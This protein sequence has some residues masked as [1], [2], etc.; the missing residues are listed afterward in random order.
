MKRMSCWMGM[1]LFLLFGLA[2]VVQAA[3]APDIQL[4]IN[5]KKI[6]SAVPPQM[7]NDRTLV[8]VYVVKDAM[9]MNVGWDSKS[10]RVT[11]AG[12]DKKIE[13]VI[14]SKKAK[15]NGS[16]RT[17]DVAPVI[18]SDRTF[19][20]FRSVGE[21]LGMN[22]DWDSKTKSVHLT[23]AT[24]EKVDKPTSV[25]TP[26]KPVAKV[27]SITGIKQTTQGFMIATDAKVEAKTFTMSTPNRIVMDLEKAKLNLQGGS[28]SNGQQ[29]DTIVKTVRYSQFAPEQVRVV[30]EL[31]G[32]ASYKVTPSGNNL[33]LAITEI[34]RNPKPSPTPTPPPVVTP[35]KDEPDQG[36]VEPTP[37]PVPIVPLATKDK[38]KIVLDAG[39]GGKDSGAVGNGLQE[40]DLTLGMAQ[41]LADLLRNDSKFELVMT[42]EGDTYPTLQDRANLANKE[43]ADLFMSIHINSGPATATGT[44]TYYYAGGSGK[45]YATIVHKHLL[46]ATGALD[47]KVRTA[48]FYVIKYTKMPSILV[49]IGF[50]TN[51]SEAAKM[52]DEDFQQG[53]ADS[54][55]TGIKEYVNTH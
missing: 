52:K 16:T 19:L 2:S 20:P 1:F 38:V 18:I 33:Q 31:D 36:T 28:V 34:S 22:V 5:G 44:E 55:Y 12:N 49:E 13:L 23:N 53:V 10:Q 25:V 27:A 32:K 8:P 26:P 7:V 37:A 15:V 51:A 50:I 47:R 24:S 17:L 43:Q 40:K 46:K 21:L 30:V 35:P 3:S 11:I 54:L 9:G 42:R 41:K 14:N 45:D 6:S 29:F 48:N 39:H 4:W